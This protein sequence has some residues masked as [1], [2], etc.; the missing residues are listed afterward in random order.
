MCIER[1]IAHNAA[2]QLRRYKLLLTVVITKDVLSFYTPYDYMLQSTR[3]IYTSFAWHYA[4]IPEN[5]IMLICHG[6][7]FAS[8]R[9]LFSLIYDTEDLHND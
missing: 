7:Y 1:L 5:T 9:P 4:I 2:D 8:G 3:G 6:P